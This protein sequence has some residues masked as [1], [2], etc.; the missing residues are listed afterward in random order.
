MA[1]NVSTSQANSFASAYKAATASASSAPS[2]SVGAT[3]KN[4]SGQ[5][6]NSG[7]QVVGG[8][9]TSGGQLTNDGKNVI[10]GTSKYVDNN[11]NGN[12]STGTI[13]PQSLAPATPINLPGA[14]LPTQSASY[15]NN[16][17]SGAVQAPGTPITL[18]PEDKQKNMLQ[19][20]ADSLGTPP[21]SEVAYKAALKESDFLAKQQRADSLSAQL[22]GIV[23]NSQAQQ[24][25]L[26][27]QGRGQTASFVGGEQARIA[28]EA[29]ITSLPIA[30]QLSAAQ[31][32]VARA[33]SQLDTLF[34][35]KSEDARNQYEYRKD[36]VGKMYE[37]ATTAE[38]RRLDAID[39]N[40]DR[41]YQQTR[42]NLKLLD[43][44][45]AKAVENGEGNLIQSLASID[46][47]S[48]RFR[49]ELGKIVSKMK[50]D[51]LKQAQIDKL[52][53]E[54]GKKTVGQGILSTLP[55]SIQG[56]LI[57]MANDFG[58]QGIVKK[59]NATLDS[60]NIVNGIKS[61]SKNPAD[62][63]T[64]VYAFAK[65]LDPESVVRE[66]EYAVIKKYAQSMVNRYGKEITNAIS[67]TGFLSQT[68]I[69]DIQTTMLNNYDSRKPQYDNLF[70]KTTDIINNIAGEDVADEILID[71][72][73]GIG[74]QS[75]GT[76]QPSLDEAYEIYTQ[77]VK[78]SP[79]TSSPESKTVTSPV[80]GLGD[81]YN[82]FGSMFGS[83][84][85]K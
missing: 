1:I 75:T 62:H 54:G 71:Y 37:I 59:Y 73:M 23:A 32:D 24:L 79:V 63:Q 28:R 83:F 36:I 41:S 33:Q 16:L 5:L 30:A 82:P 53:A 67:G 74:L 60:M 19:E 22:N 50:I 46:P 12:I 4:S 34:K 2:G 20:Y 11:L 26:E 55:V 51:P 18:S 7:G 44:Y 25:A 61:D 68:A 17:T 8:A 39:K 76:S 38:K 57:T 27:G 13:T 56:R 35:I 70:K 48:P 40:E 3:Y 81:N 69:A 84:F 31:N 65:S 78:S 21:S 85:G 15:Y 77:T 6:I 72:S 80:A 64:M 29:A 43:A 66:G 52:K 10:P 49:V 47:N 14:P 58:S 45:S 9:V 42:D